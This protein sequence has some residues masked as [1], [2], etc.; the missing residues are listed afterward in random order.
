MQRRGFCGISSL[1]GD[2]YPQY[3]A[4]NPSGPPMRIWYVPS[5]RASTTVDQEGRSYRILKSTD[6]LLAIKPEWDRLWAAARAEYFLSFSSM[7]QSWNTIHRPQGAVLRCAVAC[8]Q[9][10]LLAV[11]PMILHR[12]RLWQTASTC[13]PRAT[14]CC[15][16]L[17]ARSAESQAIASALLE[18]F[19][20]LVRPD[21]LEFDFVKLG[22]HLET[23]MRTVRGLRV[24]ETWEVDI[25]HADLKAERDWSSYEGSLGNRYRVDSSRIMRR[26]KDQGKVT[27]EVVSG[28]PTP[29]IDWLFSHKQ[30]WSERT[31]KRGAWVFSSSYRQFLKTIFS[32]DPRY[33]V[34]ALKLN[35]VPIAVILL[36]INTNSASGI[37]STYDEAYKRFSPGRLLIES[38]MKHVFENYRSVDGGHLDIVF[39]V[40]TE[41]FKMHWSRGNVQRARSYR[42]VTSRWGSARLR[43]KQVLAAARGQDVKSQDGIPG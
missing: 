15:D 19:L 21:H 10:R 9:Q 3:P 36:A 2:Y 40:G 32:S 34:F 22:S 29:L 14:E 18:K 5:G 1:R 43:V 25:P 4:K 17:I 11:L 38:M 13:G 31:N 8:D 39:G 20:V 7:Y 28:M 41:A 16:I 26:L 42:I 12:H 30:R 27:V 35:E 24:I 33:L 37:I 6:E 23:A